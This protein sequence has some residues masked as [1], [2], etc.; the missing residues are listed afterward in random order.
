MKIRWRLTWY[1]I[2][3]T[4]LTLV[5]FII[6]I[7]LLVEGS[8][9]EDQ[10][11]LLSTIA[12]EAATSLGTAQSDDLRAGIP[13]LAVDAETSDQ[14]FT[15]VYDEVGNALTAT[16]TVGGEPL[17]L[18]AAVI[19]E[20]LQEGSSEADVSDV[21]VQ[22][23]RWQNAD[24]GV[25]VVAAAQALRVVEQQLAGTRAFFI[26]FGVV[27]LI[28]A[29]VGAWFMAGRALRPL[30]QLAETTDEIGS[31]DDL[32]RRLPHVRQDDEVGALTDS[33]NGML[34]TIEESRRV[35][36]DTI[37]AQKRFVA[38]ASHEL[39]SP[40]TSI[41][42]NAGF[43][44]EQPAATPE[45]R[46]D[47]V[48]DIAAEADR[49]GDLIDG[50]ITLARADAGA[51]A[52]DGHR[53]VDLVS[54]VDG[55]ER[56]AR[57]LPL[58]LTVHIDGPVIVLGSDAELAELVWILVDNAGVHGGSHVDVTATADDGVATLTVADDGPGIPDAEREAVF[59]RFYRSDPA[60]SGPGHGLGL[61]IARTIVDRHR[62]QI[63]VTSGDQGG[64]CVVVRLPLAP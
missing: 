26:V 11:R 48:D 16:G 20:A 17:D 7:V 33:F 10:D 47:A 5:G 46:S 51:D 29:A 52:A 45:D 54:I 44:R 42:A 30:N 55:A 1:G 37:E 3:F 56:R 4:A 15:T 6:V 40:L 64:T 41:R 23:R 2:G 8:A 61:S 36:D 38:D 63:A 28:A 12:D 35:R 60:R 59:D 19:V 31:T 13:P 25:G 18:P 32:S 39:R 58:D 9:G 49:L 21:R 24:L 57:N 62:G 50:L 27:A 14:P 34:D 22:V 43:L 53:R